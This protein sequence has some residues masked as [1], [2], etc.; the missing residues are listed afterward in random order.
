MHPGQCLNYSCKILEKNIP[1]LFVKYKFTD[2]YDY[3]LNDCKI[4]KEISSL[5]DLKDVYSGDIYGYMIKRTH[6]KN[7]LF[8]HL[9]LD[10]V[11]QNNG[12]YKTKDKHNWAEYPIFNWNLFWQRL[13]EECSCNLS[14]KYPLE[15]FHIA[16]KQSV[17]L[18]IPYNISSASIFK[19]LKIDD[20][21]T[22]R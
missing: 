15:F 2:I 6:R 17:K 20:L 18:N 7:P 4:I 11:F 12:V 8:N 1:V 14:K 3:V 16:S 22:Y 21:I 9:D 5:H 10:V 13:Q 19:N